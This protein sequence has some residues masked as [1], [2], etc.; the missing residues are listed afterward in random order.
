MNM[1]EAKLF[2]LLGR[3]TAEA[4]LLREALARSTARVAELEAQAGGGVTPEGAARH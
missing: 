1:S 3:A 4:Q 2:E